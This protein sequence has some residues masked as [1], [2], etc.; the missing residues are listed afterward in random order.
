ML[1]DELKHDTMK[2]QEAWPHDLIKIIPY[3]MIVKDHQIWARSLFK[4]VLYEKCFVWIMLLNKR[5]CRVL[6]CFIPGCKIYKRFEAMC[7]CS[8][9]GSSVILLVILWQTIVFE[10]NENTRIWTDF[11]PYQL[12]VV[13][14][15]FLMKVCYRIFLLDWVRA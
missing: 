1:V 4:T 11:I 12:I 7:Y 14:A 10:D 5:P 9:V 3:K 13:L 15:C 8:N 2:N 6:I